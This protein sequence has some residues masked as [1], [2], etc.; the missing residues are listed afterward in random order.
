MSAALSWLVWL[1]PLKHQ[2]EVYILLFGYRFSC[3]FSLIKLV[4]GNCLPGLLAIIWTVFE[5]KTHFR[6]ILASLT[7]WRTSPK[8]YFLAFVLPCVVFLIALDVVLFWFPT[9]H[10]FPP[11][12]EFFKSLVLTLPFGPL[13]E[14]IAWRSYALRKLET[15]YSGL[16]SALVLGFYWTVWHIPLW[17]VTL[18][19]NQ[20]N[21]IP[22]LTAAFANLIA[23]SFIFSVVYRCSSQSLP[24]VILLHATYVA[25]SSQAGAVIPIY[26]VYLVEVSAVLSGLIAIVLAGR[27]RGNRFQS[28]VPD[29]TLETPTPSS[30]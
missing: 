6:Q 13:W 18:N 9:A 2:G 17:L 11:V 22:V 1:W 5:G 10:T 25:A 26:G 30:A 20:Q 15:R 14:E 27:L 23:W 3:P 8:W 19:L 28:G 4:V 16:V 21:K 12:K 7:N 29:T 24:I